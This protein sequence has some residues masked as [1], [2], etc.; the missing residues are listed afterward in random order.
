MAQALC[1]NLN[2]ALS[3]VCLVVKVHLYFRRAC[4]INFD[5]QNVISFND[6]NANKVMTGII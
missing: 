4:H 2:Y 5:V 6:F 3:F 1:S